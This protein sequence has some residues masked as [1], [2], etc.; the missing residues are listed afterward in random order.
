M[1]GRQVF[2]S[3]VACL[4]VAIG[5]GVAAYRFLGHETEVAAGAPP[6]AGNGD[7]P[8]ADGAAR[9]AFV[10]SAVSSCAKELAGKQPLGRPLSEDEIGTYCRCYSNGMADAVTADDVRQMQTGGEPMAIVRD[11]A[12]SVLRSCG[13]SLRSK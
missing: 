6:M 8:F 7:R 4:V 1:T 11:K 13:E 5:L 3:I 12:V 9:S 2:L 10:T